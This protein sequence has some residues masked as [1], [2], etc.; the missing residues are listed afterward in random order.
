MPLNAVTTV[1]SA[2]FSH[3]PRWKRRRPREHR[4]AVRLLQQ[5]QPEPRSE[6]Q[7]AAREL[8]QDR[9]FSLYNDDKPAT[10]G[11][12]AAGA[13]TGAGEETTSGAA[14]GASG[15]GRGVATGATGGGTATGAAGGSMGGAGPGVAGAS[16]GAAE[17]D[18]IETT[19][20][21]PCQSSPL[22]QPPAVLLTDAPSGSSW[23]RTWRAAGSKRKPDSCPH[24]EGSSGPELN[25]RSLTKIKDQSRFSDQ[26]SMAQFKDQR[27]EINLEEKRAEPSQGRTVIHVTEFSHRL[28]MRM[29]LSCHLAREAKEMK[30]L[31]KIKGQSLFSDQR[32]IVQCDMDCCS[33][34]RDQS[35]CVTWIAVQ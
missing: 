23:A 30:S 3:C 26:R 10:V 12:A 22:L 6:Q 25:E 28:N 20:S 11:T 1:P 34:T 15:A 33:V 4:A 29:K 8:L 27:S 21:S 24:G 5:L 14:R 16:T 17:E 32:S 2:T 9:H 18:S 35:C 31:N 7:V 19:H 13:S